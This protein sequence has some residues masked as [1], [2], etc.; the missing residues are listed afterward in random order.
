M[1]F[2][3]LKVLRV[4]RRALIKAETK[5]LCSHIFI[6]VKKY[7]AGGEFDK[8]KAR[9]IADGHDQE[10]S[11][12]PDK[13]SLTV[14]IHSVFMALG[15]VV[16]KK[17]LIV[18]TVDVKCAFVQTPM[19]GEPVYIRIN[20]KIMGQVIQIYPNLKEY[21][22]VDGCLYIIMQKAMYG[23]IQASSL[24]Y[25]LLKRFLEEL[26]YKMSEMDK[27][28]WRKKV[29]G[30]IFILLVY[31]DDI[32]ALVAKTEVARLKEFLIGHF[33]MVQ[34]QVGIKHSYLGMQIELTKEG[35]KF[36]MCFY[37]QQ[38]LEDIKVNEV[39]S[40]GTKSMFIV[41]KRRYC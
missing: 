22:D 40:P 29:E 39:G 7:L 14:A 17:S 2:K 37:A 3:E 5:I 4:V 33:G 20:P 10:A 34:F 27:C 28:V 12:Y 32:L 19:E 26:G 18:V 11:M 21:A 23:C 30:R 1:L 38:I 15:I 35:T 41:G 6:I 36:N 16:A 31:V 9:L 8:V 13:V 25:K 24:W